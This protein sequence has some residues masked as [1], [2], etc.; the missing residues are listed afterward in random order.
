MYDITRKI[1]FLCCLCLHA[2]SLTYNA[3]RLTH[4]AM[5]KNVIFHFTFMQKYFRG[6]RQCRG[7]FGP[8]RILQTF[9]KCNTL[10]LFCF[11]GK[12]FQR[13]CDRELISTVITKPDIYVVA[14]GLFST[15]T[16]GLENSC[17]RVFVTDFSW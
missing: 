14:S 1:P 8:P 17:F 12:T 11:Q 10:T 7:C 6:F 3:N 16:N 5:A 9:Q 4:F 2:F 13:V 15:P